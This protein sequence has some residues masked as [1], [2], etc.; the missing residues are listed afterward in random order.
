MR[1]VLIA[2]A[3]SYI[4]ES[5]A[6]SLPADRFAVE[7]LDMRGNGWQSYDFSGVDAVVQV[8]GVAHRPDAPSE[9]YYAVNRDL[10]V[11]TARRAKAAG[12]TQFVYFSSMS[13]YGLHVGRIGADTPVHPGSDYGRS[14]WE[15]EQALAALA[16]ERFHVALL[17]PPMIYGPGC[18]GNYPRLSRLIRRLPV[19]PRARGERSMLYIGCLCGFMARLLQS[20]AGGLYFPQNKEYVRIDELAA[21]IAGAHRHRLWQPRGLGWLLKLLGRSGNTIGMVFGTLVYDS[22]MSAAFADEPQPDFAQ[23][24][25]ETEACE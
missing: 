14:K 13:V 19:F 4:G 9:L 6:S 8:A 11:E 23:T 5:L 24:V 20:G 1:R 16:D 15:A 3:A 12:V 22:A 17:R 10:A 25:R 2:G 7:T 21:L 18:K